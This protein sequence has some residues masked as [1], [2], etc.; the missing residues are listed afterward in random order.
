MRSAMAM[1]GCVS[2][3]WMATFWANWEKSR[4]SSCSAVDDVLDGAGDEEVLLTQAQL[5]AGLEVLS[6]G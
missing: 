5:A 6:F 3:S 4:G 1:A 2:L